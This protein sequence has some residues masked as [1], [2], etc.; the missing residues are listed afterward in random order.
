MAYSQIFQKAVNE[1]LI[2][3]GGWVND[4]N[5]AGGETKYGIAKAQYPNLDIKN[6]TEY[7]AVAIYHRDYWMRMRLDE[8]RHNAVALEMFDT[9]VNLGCR[10]AVRIAQGALKL[11]KVDIVVDGLVGPN[12][13]A[14]INNYRDVHSLVKLMNILQGAYYLLGKENID[15][16]I[17]LVR[18]RM[19]YA[20]R[21]LR[22]WL[23]RIEI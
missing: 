20:S 18:E 23:K 17:P 4:P 1:T 21:F 19:K 12:T 14:A 16:V 7:E 15:E 22:G 5:D 13:I 2:L 11:F 8:V 3:E 6:L 9:G 10:M